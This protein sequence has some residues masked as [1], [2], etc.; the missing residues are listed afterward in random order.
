MSKSIEQLSK[1]ELRSLIDF[2][3]GMT[4]KEQE[5]ADEAEYEALA[6]A[7]FGF[8]PV[9]RPVR[10]W[11]QVVG[12]IDL[13]NPV[14]IETVRPNNWHFRSPGSPAETF[15][16]DATYGLWVF[17]DGMWRSLTEIGRVRPDV[18]IGWTQISAPAVSPEMT[19]G[20]YVDP[21]RARCLAT[22]IV[23]IDRTTGDTSVIGP[24]TGEFVGSV[25]N[26]GVHPPG[27][28][29]LIPTPQEYVTAKLRLATADLSPTDRAELV[30]AIE[31]FEAPGP[32][33]D[34]QQP[35][36]S[37][38]SSGAP[39]FDEN[40][41]LTI[42][43]LRVVQVAYRGELNDYY[44]R[45]V[46]D[47]GVSPLRSR[48]T[49]QFEV[50]AWNDNAGSLTKND[51]KRFVAM[52]TESVRVFKSAFYNEAL[53]GDPLYFRY[54]RLFIAWMTVMRYVTEE[55]TT[56]Q[57]VDR[58]SNHDLTNMLYS[59]GVYQFEDM[60][61]NYKRRFAKN[62]ET[63]LS[64]K[65]TS[66]VFKDILSI[67]NFDEDTKIWKHYLVRYFPETE[68]VIGFPRAPGATERLDVVLGT[69][70]TITGMTLQEL[71]NGL[72]SSGSFRAVTVSG[73]TLRCQR[74]AI[75]AGHGL[76]L[77]TIS[78]RTD[79]SVVLEGSIAVG[80][81][82][83][84]LPEVGFKEVDIDDKE[85]SISMSTLDLASLSDYNEFVG[86]DP[87]WETTRED[88]RKMAFSVLQTKYFSIQSGLD[89][90][91]NGLAFSFL[92]STL[93]DVQVRGREAGTDLDGAVDSV[94]SLPPL[95]LF[96]A[97]V[98]ALTLTLWKF[99]I[100]DLIPHGEGG[101]STI[102]AARTDGTPF[103]DESS[104]L[105]FSTR[106][107]RIADRAELSPQIVMDVVDSNLEISSKIESE[108]MNNVWN[109]ATGRSTLYGGEEH[110]AVGRDATLQ[111]LWD[112]KFI[113]TLQ[114]QAF[115]AID[116][117]SEW[118]DEHNPELG[119]WVR[120]LDSDGK[121]SEGILALVSLI[122]DKIESGSLNL[123]TSLGVDD[124]I[125]VYVERMIRFF[126]AYTTDLKSFSTFLLVA[127]P[128]SES[129]RLLNYIV[130]T[131]VS[132]D[133]ASPAARLRDEQLPLFSFARKDAL[134]VATARQ[135]D[136]DVEIVAAGADREEKIADH[137]FLRQVRSTQGLADGAIIF[138]SE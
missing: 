11:Q 125:M 112:Y 44:R 27:L 100:E 23:W 16:V 58:M 105:P 95:T 129:L 69:G 3:R 119:A 22:R 87:T 71:A 7:N 13:A 91:Y 118:L 74:A 40:G 2:A 48:T 59:F 36:F 106:L 96:D 78:R 101:V 107:D 84:G 51:A 70:A 61:L 9:D 6:R 128:A 120:G 66:A 85:T 68:I 73:L 19:N 76:S 17:R 135:R 121:H 80:G 12:Y 82:D 75:G 35:F 43:P 86:T 20:A 56:V 138:I 15:A 30:A 14:V 24:G 83:Y 39:I 55:M 126:K 53:E 38:N 60:P 10:S 92:W 137:D 134:T 109:G 28:S 65:G 122:E 41:Y 117:Y 67:F 37:T 127:R 26:S 94:S 64:K 79:G 33:E 1:A 133:E 123:S 32:W 34:V 50:I 132:V 25:P 54:C 98:A 5:I 88:A 131:G 116:K 4:V 77:A 62:L 113:S 31:S 114:T 89:G 8:Y 57:D 42:N 102:I 29:D 104:L 18:G 115:G 124:I 21:S 110:L 99:G 63:L 97:M 46:R 108:Q 103:P 47:S 81:I 136:G 45:M 111:R 52:H 93:K 72:V 130:R 49:E 90:V